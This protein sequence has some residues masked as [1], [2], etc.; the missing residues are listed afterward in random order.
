MFL[1]EK[2]E[3]GNFSRTEFLLH[4]FCLL[5]CITYVISTK[6]QCISIATLEIKRCT[7]AWRFL[8]KHSIVKLVFCPIRQQNSD[9]PP[10]L[11]QNA[12]RAFPSKETLLMYWQKQKGFSLQI[13]FCIY[14]ISQWIFQHSK[15]TIADILADNSW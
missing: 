12:I 2:F 14:F 13:S 11:V 1:Q 4:H 9:L 5:T 15:V 6:I 10:L 8:K 7:F 3:M